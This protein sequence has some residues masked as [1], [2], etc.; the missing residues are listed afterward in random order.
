MDN[1]QN[2]STDGPSLY[3]PPVGPFSKIPSCTYK[4]MTEP[5]LPLSQVQYQHIL[6]CYQQ[7]SN[8]KIPFTGWLLC[9]STFLIWTLWSYCVVPASLT[10]WHVPEGYCLHGCH[11]MWLA[12]ALVPVYV[13]CSNGTGQ[14]SWLA[15]FSIWAELLYLS[16]FLPLHLY[17]FVSYGIGS[18]GT[19]ACFAYPWVETRTVVVTTHVC[20]FRVKEYSN[21]SNT[22]LRNSG[23]H[24][25]DYMVSHHRKQFWSELLLRVVTVSLCSVPIFWSICIIPEGK[26][27]LKKSMKQT[28]FSSYAYVTVAPIFSTDNIFKFVPHWKHTLCWTSTYK[29]SP[30]FKVQHQITSIYLLQKTLLKVK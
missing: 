26:K 12:V 27:G 10:Y 2:Y 5:L 18:C 21:D 3:V 23:K 7:Y 8:K 29:G 30:N 15:K 25:L 9:T 6:S 17:L 13:S 1:V 22:F 4:F 14:C 20:I 24:P 16:I 19:T 28:V 11:S